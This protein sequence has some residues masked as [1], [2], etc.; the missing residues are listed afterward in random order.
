MDA[1]FDGRGKSKSWELGKDNHVRL[2]ELYRTH[3]AKLSPPT[4]PVVA[5]PLRELSRK[6][7]V[8]LCR[9]ETFDG[10]ATWLTKVYKTAAGKP[11][12]YNTITNC[13]GAVINEASRLRSE[14]SGANLL[15]A[16]TKAELEL[17]FTCLDQGSTTKPAIWLKKLKLEVARWGFERDKASG[18]LGTTQRSPSTWST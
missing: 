10:F 12:A 11:L 13:L 5:K 7:V 17:F 6:N 1:G 2:F 14:A 4:P 15:D 3:G 9:Q 8:A 16:A 18:E